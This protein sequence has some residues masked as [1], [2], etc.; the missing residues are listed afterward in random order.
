MTHLRDRASPAPSRIVLFLLALALAV[1]LPAITNAQRSA[2]PITVIYPEPRNPERFLP[3][4]LNGVRYVSTS[5]LA[6]VFGATKY[7]RPEL[8]KLSLRFGEHTL[9]LSVGA[10]V[11]LVN[12]E[13]KNLIHPATLVRGIVY[14]PET[15]VERIFDWGLASDAAWDE[16][17]RTIRFRGQ[18]H[19]VRQA[20]LTTR[21]RVTEVSATLGRSLP[22]RL[23][24]AMPGEVRVLFEGGTL[25]TAQ[26]FVGGL[27]MRG[28]IKEIPGG[29]DL[30]LVLPEE[31]RGYQVSSGANRLKVAVTDDEGLVEAGLFAPL[32][33]LRLG[34]EKGGLRTIVI[35]PGHGGS[36]LGATLPGGQAEKDVALE[37]ARSLRA[38][39]QG[40]LNARIVLTRESDLLLP[41][42]RRAEIANEAAA[43]LFISIHLEGDGA[44]KGGGFRLYAQTPAA[45]TNE[46]GMPI[47]LP[48]DGDGIELRTWRT[49]QTAFV[50]SSM[51]LAQAIADGLASS[52]PQSPILVRTGEMVVL[53]PVTCPAIILES[54]PAVR[55]GPDAMSA[56]AYTTY[57]YTQTVARAIEEFVRKSRA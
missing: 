13:A 26:V 34:R 4:V 10:P 49:A 14:V 3:L 45:A 54:A 22:A 2:A 19:S 55:S 8:Q 43:D 18:V 46:S 25:D 12:E 23:L 32:E 9:R 52:F 17:T 42:A 48:G 1:A 36:D 37:I 41:P 5:D 40:R 53:E 38:A 20:L 27:V 7:W 30:R 16:T 50:G 44:I 24:Y 6:R 35:D 51:A 57:D 28:E 39:L 11:V 56:R 33:P 21:G 15:V 31:A 29:V 47:L